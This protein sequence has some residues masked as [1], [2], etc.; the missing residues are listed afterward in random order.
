MYFAGGDGTDVNSIAAQIS[1]EVDGTPG[2][3]DMPGRLIFKTTADGAASATERLRIDKNGD[4]CL[5][6][7]PFAQGTGNTFCIHSSGTGGGDHAYLYFTNG[8]SGHSASNGMSIGLAANQVAN[9][10]VREAWPL[11]FSVNG[12]ERA[13]IHSHG[14]LELMVPDANDALKITPSGTNAHA[15]INFNTPGT[16]SAIFKVQGTERF[17]INTSGNL[18]NTG[19]STSYVTTTFSANFAKLDLRGTNIANSNHYIL[20]YGEGHANDHEFHMVN[21]IGD[22][23]FRTNA[24]SNTERLRIKSSGVVMAGMDNFSG[25]V[26]QALDIRGRYVNAEGDFARLMFRNSSDS[27]GSSASIRAL[28]T[29]DNYGTNLTF[30]TQLHGGSSGGDGLE[31]LRIETDGDMR[32]VNGDF[33]IGNSD[34]TGGNFIIF[35]KNGNS[36]PAI[37]EFHGKNSSGGG[38][39]KAQ[40]KGVNNTYAWASDLR[41]YTQDHNCLLYTSPSQ[42]DS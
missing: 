40:I 42:R 3:N 22:L 41:F 32:L 1:V 28:R 13:R 15:K 31:R 16:G 10:S 23:V 8:D 24:G 18:T 33:N 7:T 27:G 35:G 2:G 11:A 14:Q 39:P 20:S 4:M 5:G 38:N 17:S 9:I 19:Q 26:T 25:N 6:G 36:I 37:I 21:T 30:W 29:G 12:S 34:T